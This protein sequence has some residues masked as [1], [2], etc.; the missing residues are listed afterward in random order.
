MQD[1]KLKMLNYAMHYG[2]ALGF[3]WV[4]KYLFHIGA[5][6]YPSLE[7]IYG[8]LGIGTFFFL[9]YLTARYRDKANAGKISY[10]QCVAFTV[11]LSFFGSLIEAVVSYLHYTVIDPSYVSSLNREMFEIMKQMNFSTEFLKEADKISFGPLYY[12]ISQ[13]IGNVFF[14]FIISLIY[15]FI[16]TKKEKYQ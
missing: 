3:F 10:L 12:T 8:S 7:F 16:I 13:I 9:Y 2:V 6:Y 4:F 14:G 5:T 11:L 1:D 15:G